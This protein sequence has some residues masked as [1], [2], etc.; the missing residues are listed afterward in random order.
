MRD[1]DHHSEP[2]HFTYDRASVFVEALPLGRRAARISEIVGPVVR[3]ELRRAQAQTIE[4][5]QHPQ[6]SIKIETTLLC[7]TEIKLAVGNPVTDVAP[8]IPLAIDHMHVTI[9]YESLA[10][11]FSGALR[12][13]RLRRDRASQEGGNINES[14]EC[15]CRSAAGTG[16]RLKSDSFGAR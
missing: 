3:A 2:V 10:V 15:V 4:V 11:E 8:V 5:A 6:V 16:P 13:L 7:A 12:N 1:V 9:E 14:H